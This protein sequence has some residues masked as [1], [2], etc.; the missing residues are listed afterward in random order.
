MIFLTIKAIF[1]VVLALIEDIFKNSSWFSEKSEQLPQGIR[2]T[3]IKTPIAIVAILI[4]LA[5]AFIDQTEEKFS[6]PHLDINTK[7]A[8]EEILELNIAN[9]DTPLE[10]LVI[11]VPFYGVVTGINENTSPTARE[12][13]VKA[14][15]GSVLPNGAYG[16][17]TQVEFSF[18]AISPN[19]KM[20]FQIH[21]KP[22]RTA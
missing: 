16:G 4:V 18:R 1:A 6:K 8:S 5:S 17:C 22:S 11:E 12:N 3:I 2:K 14:V 9:G 7:K 20:S 21:Y 15:T 19:Q 13:V 10:N